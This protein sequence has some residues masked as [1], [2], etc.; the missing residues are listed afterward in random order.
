V[1]FIRHGQV[2]LSRNGRLVLD[3]VIDAPVSQ[4]VLTWKD[5]EPG[6]IQSTMIEALV[7]KHSPFVTCACNGR[8]MWITC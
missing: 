6:L 1:S 2:G 5:R 4:D 3:R 7:V 8:R